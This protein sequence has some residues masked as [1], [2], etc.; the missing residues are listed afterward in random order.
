MPI[1]LPLLALTLASA[2]Q[3]LRGCSATPVEHG[4]QYDCSDL[5]AR[6]EDH[7]E[8][9]ERAARYVAGMQDAIGPVLG[10]G[11]VLHRERRKLAGAEVEVGVAQ[12]PGAPRKAF[13]VGLVSARKPPGTRVLVCIGEEPR[14]D[15][16]LVHL[17]ALPW[18]SGNAAG[19]IRKDPPPLAISGRPL[20]VPEGCTSTTQP[21]GGKVEC[22]GPYWV[23][24]AEVDEGQAMR[25]MDQFGTSMGAMIQN[26]SVEAQRDDVPCR[27][28]KRDATC[29]RLTIAASGKRAVVLWGAAPGDQGFVFANCMAPRAA[30]LQLPCALVFEAR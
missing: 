22:G 9:G 7:P 10:E 18:A 27:I 2:P 21:R 14:C 8:Q 26:P 3:P 24:W 29:G 20:R 17:A 15:P 23:G 25:M 6:L 12:I 1:P 28:A 4:W 13:V 19:S 30:E 11:A 16:V 5:R